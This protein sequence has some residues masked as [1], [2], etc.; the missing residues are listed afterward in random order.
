MKMRTEVQS[1]NETSTI[2]VH[3]DSVPIVLELN[4][5]A[6]KLMLDTQTEMS[7]YGNKAIKDHPRIKNILDNELREFANQRFFDFGTHI[8]PF[9]REFINADTIYCQV[10]GTA[11]KKIEEELQPEIDE[12]DKTVAELHQEISRLNKEKKHLISMK[13]FH[14]KSQIELCRTVFSPDLKKAGERFMQEVR[15][16]FTNEEHDRF[17]IGYKKKI[18][19]II[20]QYDSGQ[21]GG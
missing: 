6:K 3:N 5:F 13:D 14:I 16:Y 2:F 15:E 17:A 11:I 7:V 8:S 18:E 1:I 20:S 19:E 21:Q 4:K 12:I 9:F 10:M